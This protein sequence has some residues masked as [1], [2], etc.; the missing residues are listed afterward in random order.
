MFTS[1]LL[2]IQLNK[3]NLDFT[4]FKKNNPKNVLLNQRYE[5]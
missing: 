5:S 1:L 3:K 2:K 4:S